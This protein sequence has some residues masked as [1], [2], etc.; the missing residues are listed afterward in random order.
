MKKN[1]ESQNTVSYHK[2]FVAVDTF[3]VHNEINC[4]VLPAKIFQKDKSC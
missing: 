4:F 3:I 1:T 2:L